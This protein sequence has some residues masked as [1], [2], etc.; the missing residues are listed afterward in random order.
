ME[1]IF[2]YPCYNPILYVLVQR[3]LVVDHTKPPEYYPIYNA[4]VSVVSIG[5]GWKQS[6]SFFLCPNKIK[7]CPADSRNRHIN[8]L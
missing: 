8:S 6:P 2:T 5:G 3:A 1:N 4:C 7:V